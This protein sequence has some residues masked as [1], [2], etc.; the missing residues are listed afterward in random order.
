MP[1]ERR[2]TRT[3]ALANFVAALSL[4]GFERVGIGEVD[5]CL[6]ALIHRQADIPEPLVGLKVGC[7]PIRL[8]EQ[9]AC[10]LQIASIKATRPSQYL[11]YASSITF[12]IALRIARSPLPRPSASFRPNSTPARPPAQPWACP[13]MVSGRAE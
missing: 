5:D 1:R 9:L 6:F 2:P 11:V 4:L 8:V 3:R 10:R 7:Q 13:M 12:N